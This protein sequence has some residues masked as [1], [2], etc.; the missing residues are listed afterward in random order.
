MFRGLRSKILFLMPL[1]IFILLCFFLLKALNHDPYFLPSAQ[2][3]KAFPTFHL[4]SLKGEAPFFTRKDLLGHPALVNVWASWC[5]TCVAEHPMLI[6]LAQSGVT[7]Y[8]INYRDDTQDALHYLAEHGNPFKK[9]VVDAK[10]SLG[11]DLGIYGTPETFVIDAEGHILYR[12]VGD[13]TQS[14]WLNKLKPLLDQS[15]VAEQI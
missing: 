6:Q 14:V 13:I 7:I 3:G 10:G 9:I 15:K 12:H 8:G 5:P 11:V 4:P 1:M 2:I